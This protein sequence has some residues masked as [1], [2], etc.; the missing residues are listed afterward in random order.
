MRPQHKTIKPNQRRA[1][2]SQAE[3]EAEAK[4][5][6]AKSRQK[7]KQAPQTPPVAANVPAEAPLYGHN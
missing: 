5:R 1:K 6:Q 7:G 3:A 4:A 2:P